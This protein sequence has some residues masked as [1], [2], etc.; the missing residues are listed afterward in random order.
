MFC[1]YVPDI[2]KITVKST[3][4]PCDKRDITLV[5]S[6][7][8]SVDMTLWGKASNLM[9]GVKWEGVTPP[10]ILVQSKLCGW[11]SVLM[12]LDWGFLIGTF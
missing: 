4:R 5:D 7:S 8:T 12:A 10:V 9:D 3:G 1:Y 2:N 11:G 6:S